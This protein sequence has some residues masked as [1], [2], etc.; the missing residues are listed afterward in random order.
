[1]A[2]QGFEKY[3][4]NAFVNAILAY[5]SVRLLSK[6]GA[7]PLLAF[8]ISVFGYYHLAMYV[9]AE[10]L[11]Y[12]TTLFAIGT[13]YFPRYRFSYLIILASIVTHLQ[14]VIIIAIFFSNKFMQALPLVGGLQLQ[15]QHPV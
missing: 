12:A 2:S 13:F 15:V 11:K 9:S 8:A 7:H 3:L 10:R 1:L 6:W 4:F 14:Y 5:F